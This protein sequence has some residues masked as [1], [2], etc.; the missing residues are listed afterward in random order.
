[1]SVLDLARPE[2]VALQAYSSARQEAAGG[3]IMLNANESPWPPAGAQPDLRAPPLNRY[4]DPQPRILV[5]RLARLYAVDESQVLVS[6]GSDE[7]IDLLVRA[8]CQPQRDAVAICPPT[9]G[10]YSTCAAVQGAQ[11]A[12]VPLTAAFTVDVDA[13]AEDLPRNVKIVFLCSPN[14]PTGALTALADIERI[15]LAMR[16]RALVVVDEAY[17]EFADAPSAAEVL[18][19]HANLGV[20]RTL[21]KAWALAG[22]R[23]GCLLAGAEIVALLRRIMPPYPLPTPSVAAALAAL[24]AD[25]LALTLQRVAVLVSERERMAGELVRL[26][27]VNAVLPSR[28][29]FLCVEFSESAAVYRHLLAA[30]VVVRDI[31]GHP[32][33]ADHLRISIGAREENARVIDLLIRQELDT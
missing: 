31:S 11:L 28:G 24:T 22:A 14:N 7:A 27:R 21:S 17:I 5:E 2:I 23:V 19:R 4:P 30:G 15:A 33:L 8:F 26:P 3:E 13:L 25:G 16:S 10:M 9:F 20:L 12:E 18:Q 29:N 1:M 6:R 32:R